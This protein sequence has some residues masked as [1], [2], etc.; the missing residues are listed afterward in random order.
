MVRTL[1]IAKAHIQ[2][3]N[4]ESGFVPLHDAAKYGNLDAIKEILE[5]NAPHMPRTSSGEFPIDFARENYH[6][7]V[8]EFLENYVPN[9]PTTHRGKW[10]HGTLSRDEANFILKDFARSLQFKNNKQVSNSEDNPTDDNKINNNET[11]TTS[12]VFLIRYSDRNGGNFVLT[13]LHDDTTKHFIIQSFQKHLFIDEGP[14]LTSLEHLVQH[15]SVFSDG[16]PTNLRYPVPP[17]PKP[18]IPLFSTMP[19]QMSKSGKQLSSPSQNSL[20]EIPLSQFETPS[21]RTQQRNLSLPSDD[22]INKVGLF[23]TDPQ[24]TPSPTHAKVPKDKEKDNLLNFRSLKLKSPKKNIIIDGMK[25]LR[26]NKKSSKQI[27]LEQQQQEQLIEEQKQKDNEISLNLMKNLTFSTDFSLAQLTQ[28]QSPPADTLYNIPTNNCAVFNI[29]FGEN[30]DA[31]V[32]TELSTTSLTSPSTN[33]S[34]INNNNEELNPNYFIESDVTLSHQNKGVEEIYFVDAPTKQFPNNNNTLSSNKSSYVSPKQINVSNNNNNV[35]TLNKKFER[36]DSNMSQSSCSEFINVVEEQQQK[37]QKD[38]FN[39]NEKKPNYFIP[40][41]SLILNEILGNG[42][43]GSVY[44]GSYRKT[45]D[46]EANNVTDTSADEMVAIKTLHDEHC[47]ANRDEFLREASVMIRLRHHCIV[48]LIGICKVCSI[49][50]S[51][52]TLI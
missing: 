6:N 43:F 18:P 47:K 26:K 20:L 9:P 38:Q 1:I 17:K 39:N 42:E 52:I 3:R 46:I 50:Y 5:A 32:S 29:D 16:L 7:K 19:K 8:V 45:E 14:Y 49:S 12:G 30:N 25:S 11:D 36:F 34:S 48:R 23:E 24:K 40:K 15:Y 4:N 10:C 35:D 13:L 21:P 33:I 51:R 2:S 31:I 27:L 41:T 22:L 44:M 28:P 37:Q